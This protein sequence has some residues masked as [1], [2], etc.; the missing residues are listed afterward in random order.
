MRNAASVV[1]YTHLEPSNPR[2]VRYKEVIMI[3]ASVTGI[4][5]LVTLLKVFLFSSALA[6]SSYSLTGN[7]YTSPGVYPARNL[8]LFVVS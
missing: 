5:T 3:I 2:R 8:Q 7:N 6:Q 1:R 4:V